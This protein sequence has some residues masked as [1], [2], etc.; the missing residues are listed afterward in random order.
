MGGQQFTSGGTVLDT[1]GMARV[2]NFDRRRG[3]V[4]VEAG[5]QWPKLVD[6]L[7]AA[8]RGQR[9]QWGIV[10]KTDR[11]QLLHDRRLGVGELPRARVGHG[12]DGRRWGV[13][14]TGAC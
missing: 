6:Y 5:I 1:R 10:Q 3:L 12:A 14:T 11:R 7:L 9:E 4:E 13:T 8:Q 2:L